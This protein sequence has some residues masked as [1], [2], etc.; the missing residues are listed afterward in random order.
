MKDVRLTLRLHEDEE[1]RP[2]ETLAST[3]MNDD[4]TQGLDDDGGYEMSEGKKGNALENVSC[5]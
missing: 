3:T 2:I 1:T 5:E 4:Q